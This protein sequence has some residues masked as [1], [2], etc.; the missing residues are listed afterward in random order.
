MEISHKIERNKLEEVAKKLKVIAHPIRIAIIEVLQ[1]N[2]SM[3]VKE[4]Q[5]GLNI[6]Q[7]QASHHLI[8]LKTNG[9]LSSVKKGKMNYYY[10]KHQI[11]NQIMECINNCG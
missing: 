9:V 2:G 3:N 1:K 4:I 6:K 11:I 10:V 8:L 7:A 5:D